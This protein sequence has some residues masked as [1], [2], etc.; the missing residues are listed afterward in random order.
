MRPRLP[1]ARSRPP[2]TGASVPRRTYPAP[3]NYWEMPAANPWSGASIAATVGTGL[4]TNDGSLTIATGVGSYG[5]RT[6]DPDGNQGN[7]LLA[8]NHNFASLS[9]MAMLIGSDGPGADQVV[10]TDDN[11][12]GELAVRVKPNATPGLFNIV[13]PNNTVIGS[14]STTSQHLAILT[15][16]LSGMNTLCRGSVDGLTFISCGTVAPTF[17]GTAFIFG[18]TYIFPPVNRFSGT[19]GEVVEWDTILSNSDAASLQ[20]IVSAGLAVWP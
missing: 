4:L 8:V 6:L 7:R 12:V 14:V 19:L 16:E 2:L 17:R 3:T 11:V 20:S 1:F 9:S 5:R 13:G 15:Y 18:S 10:M